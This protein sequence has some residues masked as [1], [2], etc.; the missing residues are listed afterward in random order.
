VRS[1][2]LIHKGQHH[3]QVGVA[4]DFPHQVPLKHQIACRFE[5]FMTKPILA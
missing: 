2:S 1:H 5:T 3:N 4:D